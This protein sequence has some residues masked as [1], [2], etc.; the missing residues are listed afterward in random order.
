MRMLT[1]FLNRGAIHRVIRES[2]TGSGGTADGE[3]KLKFEVGLA[4]RER[5]AI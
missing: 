1:A 5:D 3:R 4:G 2:F